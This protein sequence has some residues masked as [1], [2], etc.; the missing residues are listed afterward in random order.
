MGKDEFMN[1]L[2]SLLSDLPESERVEALQYYEDY[3]S[4]AGAEQEQEVVKELGSPEALAAAIHREVNEPNVVHDAKGEYTEQGFHAAKYYENLNYPEK[5]Q[6]SWNNAETSSEYFTE[7]NNSTKE[8]SH[9]WGNPQDRDYGWAAR[10]IVQYPKQRTG[11]QILWIILA[12]ILLLPIVVPVAVGLG[13]GLLVLLIGLWV[14]GGAAIGAGI[15]AVGFGITRLFTSAAYG[16]LT[17]GAGLMAFGLGLLLIEGGIWSSKGLKV[18]L[19]GTCSLV[20]RI[21]LKDNSYEQQQFHESDG[22]S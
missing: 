1:R 13:G 4:D 14:G 8:N 7:G 11:K 6:D 5:R 22:L 15:V 3:F 16:I 12:C 17:M 9:G 10:N 2:S 19:R 21:L 18:L 20:H